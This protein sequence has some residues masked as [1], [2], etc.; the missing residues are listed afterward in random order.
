MKKEADQ[1]GF[2]GTQTGPANGTKQG[3]SNAPALL[4]GELLNDIQYLIASFNQ[5]V[6]YCNLSLY[7]FLNGFITTWCYK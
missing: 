7:F 1:T 5:A 6:S 2:K 4:T 3:L